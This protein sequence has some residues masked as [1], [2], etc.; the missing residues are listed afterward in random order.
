[1]D[2]IWEIAPK[3]SED[4]R[5]KFP[6]INPIVLQLLYNRGITTQEEIDKFLS[7]DYSRDTYNPFLFPDMEKVVERIF[8]AIAK[9]EKI[10]IYSDYDVDGVTSSV[11]LLKTL[12]ELGA[13]FIDVYLPDREK[14]N[15]GLNKNALDLISKNKT[16]LLITCDCGISNFDEVEYAKKLEMDIIV[17]D[18]HVVLK[19]IPQA[20]A[21]INPQIENSYPFKYLAGVGVV[22]KI[23]QALLKR[24]SLKNKEA[25]EKWLLDL[26]ALGTI[27]DSMPLLDE[28]R[29]FVKYGLIVLNKTRNIGLRTL[30]KETKLNLGEITSWNICYQLGPKLNSASRIN[31]ANIALKLLLT[32]TI[33]QAKE[34]VEQLNKINNKRQKLTDKIIKKIKEEIGDEA[35]EFLIIREIKDLPLGLSGLIAG[36]IAAIYNRPTFIIS[37]K[38]NAIFG[39]GRSMKDFN[40]LE[41][42][43]KTKEYLLQYGGH[44]SACGFTLKNKENFTEFK[45]KLKN[46]AEEKLINYDLR[47][48]YFIEAEIKLEDVN[49]ELE[50]NLEKF[51]PFGQDNEIPYFL[52]RKLKIENVQLVGSENQHLQ[53]FVNGGRKLIYFSPPEDQKKILKPG[54]KIDVIFELGVNNWNGT[55]EL[56]MKVIDVKKS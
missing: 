20:Y 9:K 53:I 44:T 21:V 52:L 6:E 27:A 47:K 30:I 13:E 55:K 5:N 23:V 10:T 4:F 43:D 50:E 14:E 41:L 38:E 42:L 3:I 26:V 8:R 36:K 1:M 45:T 2:K 51:E 54:E 16:K 7:P 40:L 12:K 35:K 56:Q 28:N 48:K 34:I 19:K 17:T 32:E 31:H 29:V 37:L 18:H 39:S 11:V 15:Y 33:V 49:W 25:F 46:I 22:F 24:S